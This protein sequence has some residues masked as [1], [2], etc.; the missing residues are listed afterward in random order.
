M[1]VST[2]FLGIDH[3]FGE[4]PPLIFETMV[5]ASERHLDERDCQRYSTES[6]AVTGHHEMVKK[7][8]SSL[9]LYIVKEEFTKPGSGELKDPQDR[10]EV[11][12]GDD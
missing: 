9:D 6:E 3:G 2:V 4:G 12:L 5:F 8:C 10:L 1:W 11:M 7:W